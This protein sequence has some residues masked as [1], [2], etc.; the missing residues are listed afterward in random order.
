[1]IQHKWSGNRDA[2]DVRRQLIGAD[3]HEGCGADN[4]WRCD[5]AQP[6]ADKEAPAIKVE[7]CSLPN[8][9]GISRFVL[10]VYNRH[11][12]TWL[13]KNCCVALGIDIGLYISVVIYA[14]F[15]PC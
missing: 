10:A 11:M 9:S 4:G 8:K 13:P 14:L 1:M 12:L 6:A 7:H 3:R 15:G 2:I 5:Q